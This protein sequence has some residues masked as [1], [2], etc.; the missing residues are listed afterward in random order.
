MSSAL[1][2]RKVET[3]ADFRAFFAFPWTVY[4]NDPNWVPPLL[5]MRR[6]LLDKRKNPAW[7][8]CEGDF[9][10]AWRGDQIVGTIAAY[11]N[12][13]HNEFHD[14]RVGW[15]GAF[16]VLDD[17]EAARALLDTASAWVKD[18]GYPAIRGPQTFS[19]HDECGLLVD[20]LDQPPVLL[21]PY[22]PRYYQSHIEAAGFSKVMDTYGFIITREK[23]LETGLDDRLER[24]AKGIMRRNK[25]TVR[26]IETRKLK[27]EFALFKELY[28]A[29]W[30]KNWGFV[31]M[32]PRELDALVESLG[33]FFDPRL[34]FFGYVD[35]EPAGFSMAIPNL[36][37][38]LLKAYAQ[39]G[40]PE[41][42]TLVKALW[43][44]KL[45][46]SIRGARVPLLG[47]KEGLRGKGVD[48]VL[49]YHTLRALIDNG[50]QFCDSGWILESNQNMV[51][52]A[53]SFGQEIY[54]TFRFY[55]KSL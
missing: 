25:V 39:P 7:E 50:Y 34:A 51:S 22:N 16:E 5:S 37:E 18:K 26:G 47:V 13:R 10:A 21:Y 15:F 38:V 49:Y 46:P 41:I 3:P 48:A 28:N 24:I 27:A 12:H 30:E 29:A 2:V 42:V 1:T 6:D 20:G 31:P 17:A 53:K 45:R 19:T 44:W 55:E 14:E 33:N 32:T 52:I 35:G 36:N 11:I 43:H 54:K 4:K 8:Y 9:F 40:T 23:A